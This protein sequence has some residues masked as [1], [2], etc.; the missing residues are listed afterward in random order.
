MGV[1]NRVGWFQ[2]RIFGPGQ[3][4]FATAQL[5]F[6]VV[7]VV[8]AGLRFFYAPLGLVMIFVHVGW[9]RCCFCCW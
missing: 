4:A 7:V 8:A 5:D 3:F 9:R 2:S 6:D 1:G